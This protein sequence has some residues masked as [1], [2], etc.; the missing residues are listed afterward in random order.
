[1]KS[2]LSPQPEQGDPGITRRDF[3]GG[4]LVGA[5]AALLGMASPGA[6]REARAQ[7]VASPM[8]GLGPEWTGPGGIGDYAR[9]NGNTHE[10]VNA[11]HG[12]IRNQQFDRALR[13]ATDTG[14]HPDVV[15]VGCGMA[16]LSACWAYRKG[17]PTGTVLMLDQHPIFGGEAKQNEFEVD[18]YHLT[19]PQGA[20]GI[21]VPFKRAKEAGFGTHF[22]DDLGFPEEFVYQQATGLSKDILVPEDC[23]TPMHVGWERADTG[24]FYE[25]KG[26][27]R[28][29]WR[30]GFRHAP[31]P[32]A[33]KEALMQ[34][35]LYRTPPRRA[36]WERWLDSMTYQQFLTDVMGI[37]AAVLPEVVKYLNPMTA[38]MGCGL[39]A[40][41]ISAYSAYNFIQPGVLGYSRYQLGGADPT[42]SIYLASFPGGHAGTARHFLK[43]ILP[44]AL[45]GEYRMADIL[46][47]PVQ[48]DQLDK[49]HEPVRMRLS[50][51]VVAVMHEGPPDTAR[52]VVVTYARGGKLYEVRAKAAILCGQQ[53]ANRHICRDVPPEYREAM[54]TFHHAP[55]LTVNVAVRNWKFLE[56]LGIAA[57]RWFEGFGWWLSLRRNLEIPGQVTQP[58][59]PAKPTVLTMYNP[60]PLPGVPFPQQC[61][62]ARM[63]LFNMSYAQI[64]T[65]VREQFTRMFGDYGFDAHRDIAGII[66][67]RW[68][69]AYVVDP[70]GFFFGRDGKPAPKDILTRRFNR[71]SF[72]HSEL[73]G[74]QMWETAAGEGERAAQQILEVA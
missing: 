54:N 48:W 15:I 31:L 28:N 27:V 57:A 14:E 37:D 66:T 23:W 51:T 17:R 72:G 4:T 10:V 50:A 8:T 19:A 69:H 41:V 25:G 40:D 11:A 62:L 47:S 65:A 6:M 63:Q 73:T 59:D 16:G 42:D 9:S 43:K 67:N 33:A 71:L 44:A 24:F 7:T 45:L 5:G 38:A 18:G 64:E 21:V 34:M 20:T 12:G 3:V 52:G 1:M 26:W 2:S 61:T 13:S 60:F 22:S 68:G 30:D 36:D 55:M 29:P 53:H 46:N 74:M 35:E 70:P 58:L 49:P 39:G 32:E 56:R